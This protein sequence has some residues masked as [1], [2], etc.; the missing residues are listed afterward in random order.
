MALTNKSER[1]VGTTH[2]FTPTGLK[3]SHTKWIEPMALTNK[4]ES[5][6]GTSHFVA[7]D[8]NPSGN[9]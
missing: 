2:F 4:R 9:I 7:T 8:F 3:S 1:P 5:S 6:I